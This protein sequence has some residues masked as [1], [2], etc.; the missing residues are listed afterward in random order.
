MVVDMDKTLN[1]LLE[2]T[3]EDIKDED[4]ENGHTV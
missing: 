2:K 1:I 3:I 4:F